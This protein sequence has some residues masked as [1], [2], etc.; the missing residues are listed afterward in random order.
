MKRKLDDDQ[1][2]CQL[3]VHCLS[4]N[5][6]DDPESTL[7]ENIEFLPNG[8]GKKPRFTDVSMCNICR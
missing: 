6:F 7:A 1:D 3:N 8:D 5:R 4:S 2:H